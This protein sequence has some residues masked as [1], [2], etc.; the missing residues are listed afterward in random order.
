MNLFHLYR[1]P[2]E[3]LM[4]NWII[5][6]SFRTKLIKIKL[7]MMGGDQ[8]I[9]L[10]ILYRVASIYEVKCLSTLR[11][12]TTQDPHKVK[13]EDLQVHTAQMQAEADTQALVKCHLCGPTK[14]QSQEGCFTGDTNSLDLFMWNVTFHAAS[15]GLKLESWLSHLR[16]W[17]ICITL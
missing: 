7:V 17:H 6:E 16:D 9:L 12:A 8:L 4:K 13:H 2:N 3:T 14:I 15:L 5:F 11:A 10:F 1:E